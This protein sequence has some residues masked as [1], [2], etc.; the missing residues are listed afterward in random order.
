MEPD[1]LEVLVSG[2]LEVLGLL[3][4]SSNYVFL[5]RSC[6]QG[7]EAHGVYKPTRGER[8]L[9]DFPPGTLAAREVAAFRVSEAGGWDLVPPTVLRPDA[10]MGEGS[11]QMFVEH[12][13]ERHY[14][15]LIKERPEDFVPFA[16]FD[17]VINNGDR[18]GGHVIEDSDGRLWGV[19]HGLSFNVDDKLRTVIWE[20]AGEPIGEANVARLEA[21]RAALRG[22]GLTDE[23]AALLSLEE[24]EATLERTESLLSSG[25]FPSPESCYRLP[26][27]LV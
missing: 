11:L 18:K 21:T 3:P 25:V 13:P 14:F 4:Y 23:I 20:F 17:I 15:T 22:G 26:W 1:V 7:C 10:P 6:L 5:A 9:W 19:D 16:A 12:D 24:A 8:P 27:P 2:D